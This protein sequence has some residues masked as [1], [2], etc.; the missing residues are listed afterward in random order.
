MYEK[1]SNIAFHLEKYTF[2]L[3]LPV[4]LIQ[5]KKALFIEVFQ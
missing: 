5:Q 3:S 1:S 2:F 4:M